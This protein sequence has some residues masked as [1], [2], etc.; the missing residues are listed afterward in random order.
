MPNTDRIREKLHDVPHK[1]GVYIMRDRFGKVIYVGKA[2]DLRRRVGQYFQPSRRRG[3]DIKFN[4][5]V[6]AIH[7]FDVYTV[8]SEPEALLLE[9]R[10]IK[11]YKPRYN[12]SF[13]DDKRFLLIKVN[14]N[15]KIPRFALTRIR[16]DDGARYFGPFPSS[17]AV[18]RTMTILRSE[19]KVRSCRALVPGESDYKHCLYAHLEHCTA[20]CVGKVTRDEYLRQITDACEFLSGKCSEME[21]EFEEEMKKAA[22]E[23]KFEKAARLRDALDAL[24]HTTRRTQRYF[25]IPG[26]LPVSLEPER[27]LTEL[28]EALGLASVPRKIEGFDISNISGTFVVASMVSFKDGIPDKSN[29][30]RYNI[31]SVVGQNDFECMAEV[32]RRRYTRVLAEMDAAGCDNPPAGL[33]SGQVHDK[34]DNGARSSRLPDLILIDGGIPQLN[35]AYLELEKLGISHIPVISIA[36]KLEEVFMPGCEQPLRLPR[37]N[38]ALLLLQHVRDESHRFA[39]AYNAKLRMKKISESIL[40]E[41]P[42]I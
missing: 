7:D 1:P 37:D 31:K 39:H 18:R 8:K 36:K 28:A 19:F 32:V 24:R 16:Q 29:Y 9:G 21:N 14:L 15:D 41:F 23:L 34:A 35:A 3:W 6:D 30:R 27:G 42:G 22:E 10:L 40:D 13:R 11:D 25:R 26:D 5:L 17:V 2:R 33:R 38:K 20:P 12:I 4:A